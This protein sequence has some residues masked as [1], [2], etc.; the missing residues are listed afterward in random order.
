MKTDIGLL[1]T[2]YC[3]SVNFDKQRKLGPQPYT[4]ATKSRLLNLLNE[5]LRSSKP[6]PDELI[7]A[8]YSLMYLVASE[9]FEVHW[10]GLVT[11]VYARGG[12]GGQGI[13][14]I[15][16]NLVSIADRDF[17]ALFEREPRLSRPRDHGTETEYSPHIN[18]DSPLH[19]LHQPYAE[20]RGHQHLPR[21]VADVLG[22]LRKLTAMVI[23][24]FSAFADL[25]P[26]INQECQRLLQIV[27]KSLADHF[28]T[29]KEGLMY[30]AVSIA[31]RVYVRCIS[32]GAK[33]SEAMSEAELQDLQHILSTLSRNAWDT[34]P[35][36]L[37]FIHLVAQPAAR[38][39]PASRAYFPASQQR[40]V[41]PL[42]LVMYPDTVLSLE[43]FILVQRY[44]RTVASARLANTGILSWNLT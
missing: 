35:G 41:A 23:E 38:L 11:M 1:V 6:F 32:E 29:P 39:I 27:G 43:T 42:A 16:G 19:P 2:Q 28:S 12:L 31:A 10:N 21:I 44:I 33:F 9:D 5:G 36:V 37:L 26:A 20:F 34:V 14:G 4:V 18:M 7:M 15:V 25:K 8:V 13:S 17:A 24:T 3:A 40:L 30:E 22:G